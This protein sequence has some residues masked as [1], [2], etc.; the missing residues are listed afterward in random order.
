ML[1]FREGMMPFF[2]LLGMMKRVKNKN[3]TKQRSWKSP[4]VETTNASAT[5]NG[6][7]T[8]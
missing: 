8:D 2:F 4:P 1:D 7:E 5:K 3:M 6:G